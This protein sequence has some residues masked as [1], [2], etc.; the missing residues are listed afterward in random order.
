S[1]IVMNLPVL[2]QPVLFCFDDQDACVHYHACE[3]LYSISKVARGAV[4]VFFNAVI[5]RLYK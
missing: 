2:V 4:I 5:N 3:S 1:C